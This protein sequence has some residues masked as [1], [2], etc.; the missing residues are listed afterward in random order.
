[1][2]RFL[3]IAFFF[4]SL[5][6]FPQ[7]EANIWH[8]GDYIGLD[9]NTGSPVVLEVPY[10]TSNI[11]NATISDSLGNLLF[12]C[13]T[14]KIWNRNGAVMLNGNNLAGRPGAA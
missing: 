13:G 4:Y 1:M 14:N 10:F 8:F 7:K 3:A 6:S 9:F 12:S 11:G 2:N 5:T